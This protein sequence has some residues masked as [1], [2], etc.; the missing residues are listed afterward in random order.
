M[1]L[2]PISSKRISNNEENYHK[3]R[4]IL[5]PCI[6]TTH[7]SS[8]TQVEKQLEKNHFRVNGLDILSVPIHTI[9]EFTFCGSG[10]RAWL[11]LVF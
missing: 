8:C 6:Y 2:I 7:S 3:I 5:A 10:N 1:N 9:S 11:D 4:W